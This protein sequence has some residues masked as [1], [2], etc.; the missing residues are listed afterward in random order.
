MEGKFN[1]KYC[2]GDNKTV[3]ADFRSIHGL[4]E[5]S[6]GGELQDGETSHWLL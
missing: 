1:K 5:A 3:F 2:R 6:L 4:K